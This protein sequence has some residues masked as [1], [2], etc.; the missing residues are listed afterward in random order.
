M[1]VSTRGFVRAAL[2]LLFVCIPAGRLQAQSGLAPRLLTPAPVGMNFGGLGYVYSSGNVILDATLPLEDT[3]ARVHTIAASYV[4]SLDLFGLTGRLSASVPFSHGEWAG[5][6]VGVDSTTVRNG[7]GDPLVG[8]GIALLGAPAMNAA[9]LAG[10]R[11]RFLLGT[12]VLLRIPLGQYDGSRSFNLGT[13]RWQVVLG[14]GAA[15]YAGRWEFELQARGWFSTTNDDFLGG[16]TLS[17][18]P[19]VGFQIHGAY[20]FKRGLWVALSVGQSF[21][22]ATVVNDVEQDNAQENNRIAATVAVPIHGA[23]SLKAAYTVGVATRYGGDFDVA[24]IG[25]NYYWGGRK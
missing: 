18:R 23:W 21:G 4:R 13:N 15:L 5:E 3:E 10:Y 20:S 16:N 17:Q 7:V 8:L 14:V 24:A 9:E 25:V 19:L 11:R 12:S 6:V 1:V 2:V 22:G